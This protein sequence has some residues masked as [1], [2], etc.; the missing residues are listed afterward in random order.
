[1]HIISNL[2]CQAR[3]RIAAA[4]LLGLLAANIFCPGTTK[5]EEAKLEP[6][7][8][9][10]KEA[11]S[12][13]QKLALCEKFLPYG[14][15]FSEQ[16]L[17][18][19]FKRA[20]VEPLSDKEL[21]FGLLLPKDWSPTSLRVTK[22]QLADDE[23]MQIP[24]LVVSPLAP[25]PEVFIQ[26]RYMRV[27]EHVSPGRF[28]D[29]YAKKFDAEI[30]CRQNASVKGREIED[31]LLKLKVENLGDAY[32]RITASRR[33]PRMFFIASAAPVKQYEIWKKTFAVAAVSFD[34]DRL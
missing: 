16:E 26:V 3:M 33:G 20:L 17:Q 19:R 31:A 22:E 21:A 9:V 32:M 5:A 1:M 8:K 28:V 18:S 27:P 10:Q 12:S 2:A 13:L 29:V 24:L 25:K 4:L 30:I 11:D 14:D 34:L 7:D 6:V 23:H 15:L